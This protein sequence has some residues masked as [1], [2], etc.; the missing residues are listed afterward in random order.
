M[1]PIRVSQLVYLLKDMLEGSELLSDLWVVG[2]VA[3]AT[4]SRLGHRYFSLRDGDGAI[5]SVLFRDDMPG[6]EVPAGDR[7]LAHGRVTVYP[8]RGELQFVCDFFRPEG[9]GIE[10]ARLERLRERLEEEGLFELSRKRPL[11]AYPRRI[12]VVTSPTG[13]A[14]QDVRDVI[15][16]RWPLA[17]LVIAP[18]L[19]QG[20]RAPDSIVAALRLLARDD[21]LDLALLVRGGGASADLSAFNDEAVVRAVFAFPVP[22]VTG[23]GHETDTSL[24]DLAADLRAP[25]PSA[26]A[27]AAT[28]DA[29]EVAAR[30]DALE[31]AM[32]LAARGRI[33]GAA[34][35]LQN[36]TATLRHAAPSPAR[37]REQVEFL[38]VR[39]GEVLTARISADRAGLER[40]AA[41]VTALNP[42]TTLARGYAIV[43]RLGRR[44]RVVRRVKDVKAGNRIAVS[45]GDG[46]FWAEVN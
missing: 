5:R 2:E 35:R 28:P 18:A 12:G 8:Q 43:E 41:Q 46:A 17:E 23:I 20:D 4:R 36:S 9:V 21:A 22:V 7:V 37:A 33:E 13:A 38:G 25:T 32:A 29:A 24:A 40:T 10:A 30:F 3:D 19:V 6:A 16:R 11:P 42:A 26:A 1:D 39:M 34:A 31:R 15:A 45:V 44:R 27:A 14:V